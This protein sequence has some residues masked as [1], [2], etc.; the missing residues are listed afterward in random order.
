[1]AGHYNNPE[2]ILLN[3]TLITNDRFAAFRTDEMTALITNSC[4]KLRS[5]VTISDKRRPPIAPIYRFTTDRYYNATRRR[6]KI[7]DSKHLANL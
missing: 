6:N 4:R 5:K 3:L 2:I 1:M 7:R